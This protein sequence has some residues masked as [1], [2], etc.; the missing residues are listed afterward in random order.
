MDR[1]V[2][3]CNFEPEPLKQ[4]FDRWSSLI[5]Q[6]YTCEFLQDSAWL[7]RPAR[8]FWLFSSALPGV[9]PVVELEQFS[10]LYQPLDDEVLL[11]PGASRDW[12]SAVVAKNGLID[13]GTLQFC[14]RIDQPEEHELAKLIQLPLRRAFWD[15]LGLDLVRKLYAESAPPCKIIAVDADYTLWD[16]ACAEGP[17]SVSEE[18]RI[19]HSF[20]ARKRSEGK[21]LCLISKN[22][23]EDIEA[24]FEQLAEGESGLLSLDD[25]V[26][27]KASWDEKAIHLKDAADTLG[28]DVGSI[29]FLDDNAAECHAVRRNLPEVTVVCVPETGRSKLFTDYAWFLD[30]RAYESGNVDRTPWYQNLKKQLSGNGHESEATADQLHVDFEF[31]PLNSLTI[32][33][34]ERVAELSFRTSQFN[35]SGKRWIA[36]ELQSKANQA[37]SFAI[38]LKD[39]HQDYG[40]VG[41]AVSEG[42]GKVLT[43]QNV[44]LSCRVL[45]KGVER[46]A[47]RRL[48]E[49]AKTEGFEHVNFEFTETAR[50]RPAQLWL[51]I[52]GIDGSFARL[53][54]MEE[55]AFPKI[56]ALTPVSAQATYLPDWEKLQSASDTIEWKL[57]AL[58][59]TTLSDDSYE[60]LQ[61]TWEAVLDKKL[62]PTTSIFEEGADSLAVASFVAL[63]RKRTGLNVPLTF[64]YRHPTLREMVSAIPFLRPSTTLTS[65]YLDEG[66]EPSLLDVTVPIFVVTADRANLAERCIKSIPEREGNVSFAPLAVVQA[67]TNAVEQSY[68]ERLAAKTLAKEELTALYDFL[69]KSNLPERLLNFLL[70]GTGVPPG[71]NK[72]GINRNHSLLLGAGSTFVSMDDDA[73]WSFV[74]P[75][76]P[77]AG[78]GAHSDPCS[79]WFSPPAL[80]AVASPMEVLHSALL[81]S[82]ENAAVA[83]AGIY[84][85]CGLGA[86]FGIWGRPYGYLALSG[87][88]QQR[89][90]K[91]YSQNI[92]SRNQLRVV[93]KTTVAEFAQTICF[94]VKD[95]GPAGRIPPFFP[96]GR[97]EDLIWSFAC[98]L[99]GVSFYQAPLAVAHE[100]EKRKPYGGNEIISTAR[101]IDICRYVI[102]AMKAATVRRSAPMSGVAL[103]RAMTNL[104]SRSGDE[105]HEAVMEV[106]L[107]ENESARQWL[108]SQID[109]NSTFPDEWKR[110]VNRYCTTLSQAELLPDYAVPLDLAMDRSE[111]LTVM[112]ESLFLFG[113][114]LQRWPEISAQARSIA[115][116]GLKR[117]YHSTASALVPSGSQLRSSPEID[118]FGAPIWLRRVQFSPT[119]VILP[120]SPESV[121]AYLRPLAER[122]MA[123]LP[124][125]SVVILQPYWLHGPTDG[126]DGS[127][128]QALEALVARH[129]PEIAGDFPVILIAVCTGGR[130]AAA[131]AAELEDSGQVVQGLVLLESYL[132]YPRCNSWMRLLNV[133]RSMSR[134]EPVQGMQYACDLAGR[135]CQ[136]AANRL[137]RLFASTQKQ[138]TARGDSMH[139]GSVS[140]LQCPIR[141]HRSAEI[142]NHVVYKD[143]AGWG[144]ISGNVRTCWHNGTRAHA[145]E[146]DVSGFGCLVSDV[147]ELLQPGADE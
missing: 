73:L 3:C 111:A 40:V 59:G 115:G 17:I 74:Y 94:A 91:N 4:S 42:L 132:G 95:Q 26:Y 87:A 114:S 104:V 131:I 75:D 58:S 110:D 62:Q 81:Q 118:L 5:G 145:I 126:T 98:Q 97:G 6:A 83:F 103:G 122:L 46:A 146:L 141:L 39:G 120:N 48:G 78:P 144:A 63:L 125:V 138:V 109:A 1:L 135:W 128:V 85:D 136:N 34:I 147:I 16:G 79:Y 69:N 71:V 90:V 84:G 25:F 127:P 113:E 38:S 96:F 70:L 57:R 37:L 54:E 9:D 130:L 64:P 43:V 56:E 51:S 20:L 66:S 92:R 8:V 32:E 88:S 41:A 53:I 13:A 65:S 11:L 106:I 50:N 80:N 49:L 19:L 93:E 77:F 2:F 142:A 108:H 35:F 101:G 44:F 140:A 86:P 36:K 52:A 123:E 117:F 139:W 107:S 21:L 14:Q 27:V 31:K 100:P 99:T 30:R 55:T 129:L 68:R 24:A 124:N 134:F 133:M 29:A 15:A 33:E 23:Q 105:M 112:R 89:F 116:F 12:N 45:G 18:Y 82:P 119:I 76:E 67:S 47:L 28:F 102:A 61:Q 7:R 143:D 10:N 60:L 72:V 137:K 121:V 22:N